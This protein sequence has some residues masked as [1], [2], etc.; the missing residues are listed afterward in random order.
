MVTQKGMSIRFSESD[1]R[2]MGRG[3]AGV[4]GIRLR[5]GDRVVGADIAEEGNEVLVITERGYG[6]RTELKLYRIQTRGG[7]GVKAMQL[8]KKTG[9]I[10]S[11]RFVSEK[12]EMLIMTAAGQGI[13]I[14]VADI[15]V[16]GRS[17]QGVKLIDLRDEDLVV[18]TT[19][20]KYEDEPE[21]ACDASAAEPTL[22]GQ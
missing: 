19:V 16:M 8:T 22:F 21:E 12:D 1:V 6:K 13:K 4:R 7:S 3:A 9:E 11:V 17:T 15:S 2:S 5:A 18:S 14:N 20:I 10:V